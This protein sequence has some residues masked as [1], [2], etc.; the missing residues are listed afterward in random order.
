M[1]SELVLLDYVNDIAPNGLRKT[2]EIE[3]EMI[4]SYPYQYWEYKEGR[5]DITMSEIYEKSV[6]IKGRLP[7][8][9]TLC[10][11]AW[12]VNTKKMDELAL[13]TAIEELDLNV[14]DEISRKDLDIMME[15]Y[16][17]RFTDYYSYNNMFDEKL[18][19]YRYAVVKGISYTIESDSEAY[20][21]SMYE[22][23]VAEEK[24]IIV[25]GPQEVMF[26]DFIDEGTYFN[27]G[28]FFLHYNQ[29]G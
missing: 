5:N 12:E 15:E 1:S 28:K 19:I 27:Y 20:E 9:Q 16:T 26:E 21:D 4:L 17:D 18:E 11:E 10:E 24:D 6:G 8:L 14:E 7:D 29:R 3:G 2:E 23:D 22:F 13:I 25:N